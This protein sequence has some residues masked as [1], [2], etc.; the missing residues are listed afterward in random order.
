M[1]AGYDS[2]NSP[3]DCESATNFKVQAIVNLYG[4]VDLT[5]PY[6]SKRAE[7]F[8]FLGKT[9]QEDPDLYKMASPRF[10]ISSDDPPTLTFHGTLD[11]LVPVSQADSLHSWLNQAGIVSEYHRLKG[12]PHTMDLA[13]KVNRYCQ[14]HMD[15]FLRKHL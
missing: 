14:Y 3:K 12:W 1:M 15:E 4:P 8:N 2:R 6:A 9:F 7:V 5:T 11:S 13:V 10:L